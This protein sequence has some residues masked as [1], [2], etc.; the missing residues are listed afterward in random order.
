MA[1]FF[2]NSAVRPRDIDNLLA[3][4]S[5][6]VL[7]SSKTVVKTRI[8]GR[9][10]NTSAYVSTDSVTNKKSNGQCKLSCSPVVQPQR[11]SHSP[12]REYGNNVHCKMVQDTASDS[13]QG[14]NLDE[15]QHT[16][17]ENPSGVVMGLNPTNHNDKVSGSNLASHTNE[18]VGSDDS[19]GVEGFSP[20]RTFTVKTTLV[21]TW[22]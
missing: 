5:K 6:N 7:S 11:H 4:K 17:L 21:R 18:S 15:W 19:V 10:V 1:R 9:G 14:S 20:G 22:V 2:Y 13:A 16:H 12:K 8:F 3:K